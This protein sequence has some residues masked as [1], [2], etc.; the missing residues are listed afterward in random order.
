MGILRIE[1]LVNGG[2]RMKRREGHGFLKELD[3]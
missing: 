3:R 2:P 1:I